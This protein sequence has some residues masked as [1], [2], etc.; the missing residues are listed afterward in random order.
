MVISKQAKR[1]LSIDDDRTLQMIVKQTLTKSFG[2]DVLE[3][4][5]VGTGEEGLQMMREIQPDIILC[6]IHMPG[7][8]GFEVCQR[9]RELKLRSAVILMSAYDAEQDNA[10]KASE[11][12]ADAYLSK[13]LKKGELL[14][15]VNFVIRVAHLNDTVFEKNKQLEVSLGQ[16]KQFHHKFAS[17]NE[18]LRN[19]KRRLGVSLK[20]MTELNEQLEN[21]NQQ[22]SSMV[23]ELANRF[24]STEGLLATIIELHQTEHR[25]HS[26]R[27]AN[28]AVYISGKLGLTDYQI[29]NVKSAARLHELGIVAS[30][31]KE[32]RKEALNEGERS[33]S[34]ASAVTTNH[35]LVGEMLLKEF[36][37][38]ELIAEIIRHL[39][40]NVDG[41]GKPD[42]MYG[43]RI[44]IGSRIVCAASYFDHISMADPGK[45]GPDI[46]S[47][48]EEKLGVIFDE[49]VMGALT[50]YVDS[51][52]DKK[53]VLTM[54]CSV[55]A[56]AEGM[57]LAAD[58]ISESGI[59]LLRKGTVLDKET[60]DKILKFHNVDPISK[61]IKVKQ[62]S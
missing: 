23:E 18:E 58:I 36:P 6:D 20:E 44:P 29:R 51:L 48:M 25:G 54:D 61:N 32:K 17:L 57:E 56:L 26:E 52:G 50:E 22:I 21:K 47:K 41:S 4:F 39:H 5:Q 14:F 27:V 40:E 28:A 19:D 9:V 10:I 35:P 7:M 8:D 37:G 45:S 15:V 12:G 11:T 34:E 55:F 42:G 3:V 2:S 49:A 13:P 24:D 31:T 38:F 53:E 33:E 62:P 30:P 60:L 46:L 16:L 59:N 43:D 1:F